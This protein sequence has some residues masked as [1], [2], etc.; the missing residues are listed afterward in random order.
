MARAVV[1]FVGLLPWVEGLARPELHDSVRRAID[2]AFLALCHHAPGRTL[3]LR[4]AAMC[5]CSR[6]AGLYAGVFVAGLWPSAIAPAR[7]RLAL[8]AGAA[9]MI[10]DI[11]F[12]ELGLHPPWH[13]ARLATGALV[14]WAAPAR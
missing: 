2:I 7:L 10:A 5:V 4:G 13:A 14:G 1:A 12:Q 11:L 9:L 3:V 6:C 8:P